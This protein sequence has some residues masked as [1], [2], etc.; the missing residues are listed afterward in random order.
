MVK[1]VEEFKVKKLKMKE[2]KG[3]VKGE[4]I[5]PCT[6]EDTFTVYVQ[7][8]EPNKKQLKEEN[9]CITE[10]VHYYFTEKDTCTV[11]IKEDVKMDNTVITGNDNI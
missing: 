5:L 11:Y 2:E 3:S 4:I 6:L 7:E 10:E 8:E 1:T 9:V